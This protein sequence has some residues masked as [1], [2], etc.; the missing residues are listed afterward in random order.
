MR[1][2]PV[3]LG[4]IGLVIGLAIVSM[5]FRDRF[6]AGYL[7]WQLAGANDDQTESLLDQLGRLGKAGI[8]AVVEAFGSP[9]E[10]LARNARNVLWQMVRTD[11][12]SRTRSLEIAVLIEELARHVDGFSP[13]ARM[14]AAELA[15]DVLRRPLDGS[16]VDRAAVTADCDC[17][18]KAARL[19]RRLLADDVLGDRTGALGLRPD[20]SEVAQRTTGSEESPDAPLASSAS[21]GIPPQTDLALST[22]DVRPGRPGDGTYETAR[23]AAPLA[24]NGT[25]DGRA[26]SGPSAIPVAP[27]GIPGAA[28]PPGALAAPGT[29]GAEGDETNR[30][31]LIAADTVDLMRRL[32]SSN[33][34]V[35]AETRAELIRRGFSE[36]LLD[37]ARRLFDPDPEV[38]KQLAR[39]LPELHSIDALPWLLRL[40]RDSDSEVRLLALTLLAT[41][42]DPTMLSRVQE[43]AREDP[44]PGVQRQIDHLAGRRGGA[45]ESRIR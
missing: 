32:Q 2:F 1:R 4:T 6:L 34:S 23:T 41:T 35:V 16:V 11:D 44:D 20:A 36:I 30:R 3:L 12:E 43:I 21:L 15:L 17:V 24:S 39:R 19:E 8:P 26:K 37:L 25:D 18:L 33:P 45:S 22:G 28:L 14:D 40:T 27:S 29:A 10:A 13:A 42:G 5:S 31:D 9:R 7:R 38:R